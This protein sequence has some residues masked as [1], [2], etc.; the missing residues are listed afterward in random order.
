[1]ST[2]KKIMLIVAAC[3]SLL[4]LTVILSA[5]AG[6]QSP[7]SDT[8]T[9]AGWFAVVTNGETHYTLTDDHGKTYLLVI[10]EQL[11]QA[12]GGALAFDR[13]RVIVTGFL[14]AISPE[15]LDVNSIQ[16]ESYPNSYPSP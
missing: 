11:L 7:A 12:S 16:L 9:V 5:C 13:K 10:D 14:K 3:L 1:M 2:R 6:A 4:G 8:V 15:T